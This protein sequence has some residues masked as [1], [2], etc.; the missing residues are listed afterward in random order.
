MRA[1]PAGAV[2]TAL[3]LA[4]CAT[5]PDGHR[6]GGDVTTAPGWT[7]VREAA[8]R[9]ATDPWVWVRLAGAA[10]LQVDNF[11][12]WLSHWGRTQD[13]IF[14]SQANATLWSDRLRSVSVGVD[15]AAVLFTPS[16]DVG[17]DW[18]LGQGGRFGFSPLP[19]GGALTFAVV[20]D[21]GS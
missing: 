21:A 10:A 13:P 12:Q 2:L 15:I 8:V 20:L 7:R 11:D 18:L 17:G 4:G 14:G 3:S 1:L 19:G 16:G 6:W 5:L 9:A